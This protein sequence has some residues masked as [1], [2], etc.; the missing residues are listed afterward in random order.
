MQPDEQQSTLPGLP[1]TAPAPV[2]ELAHPWRAVIVLDHTPICP[3]CA[4]AL[5]PGDI[6]SWHSIAMCQLCATRARVMCWPEPYD[7]AHLFQGGDI[8]LQCG[9]HW[10]H[11]RDN[12]PEPA[13]A[14]RARLDVEFDRKELDYARSIVD[15]TA[16][17]DV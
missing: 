16:D 4:D 8:E 13:V 15:Q 12:R 7:L 14:R 10:Y 1:L 5:V 9:I 6:T 3:L 17:E 2:S 11:P